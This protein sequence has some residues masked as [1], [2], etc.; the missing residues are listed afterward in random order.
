MASDNWMSSSFYFLKEL[1]CYVKQ[2]EFGVVRNFTLVKRYQVLHVLTQ[3]WAKREI[4]EICITYL[5]GDLSICCVQYSEFSIVYEP[6]KNT[7]ASGK[8]K[9]HIMQLPFPVI[10]FPCLLMF[11]IP[12]SLLWIVSHLLLWEDLL[13]TTCNFV[14]LFSSLFNGGW[15]P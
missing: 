9:C 10:L 2:F 11:Y 12:V 14:H 15:N 7:I 6:R 5:P 4:I 8:W 1:N 13:K 3:S